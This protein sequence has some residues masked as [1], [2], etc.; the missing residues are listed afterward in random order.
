MPESYASRRLRPAAGSFGATR[1]VVPSR[2]YWMCSM[3]LCRRSPRLS[4]GV[5]RTPALWPLDEGRPIVAKRSSARFVGSI[6]IGSAGADGSAREAVKWRSRA[7]E[8]DP[9]YAAACAWRVGAACWLP[10]FERHAPS[11]KKVSSRRLAFYPTFDERSVLCRFLD[12][13]MT[14]GASSSSGRHPKSAKARSRGKP[15]SG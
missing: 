1:L 10:E 9:T 7:I 8:D 3:R 2:I 15:G 6:I 12:A 14:R 5:W 4:P 11:A 13:G